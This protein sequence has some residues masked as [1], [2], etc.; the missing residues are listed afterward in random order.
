[1]LVSCACMPQV[2]A[3]LGFWV[4]IERTLSYTLALV[5]RAAREEGAQV[6]FRSSSGTN[7]PDPLRFRT[8]PGRIFST[9]YD[10]SHGTIRFSSGLV[11]EA[12][13]GVYV[14]GLAGVPHECD[15]LVIDA[16][17]GDFCRQY[18]V[19]PKKANT[20][21][22]LQCKFYAGKLG[23]ALGREFL[24]VTADTWHRGTIFL[25]QQ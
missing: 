14:T 22:T 7:N 12:H 13:I 2:Y 11:L 8:S 10:Y 1:M 9:A 5:L 15:V 21:L 4:R 18:Q 20:V 6:G 23:I 25:K 17:E 24:G 16:V 19:H 3:H